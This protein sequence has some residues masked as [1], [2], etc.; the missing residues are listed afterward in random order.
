MQ[1][2]FEDFIAIKEFQDMFP[3]EL[4]TYP[5]D[6]EIKLSIDLAPETKPVTKALHKMAP[7]KMRKLAKQMQEMLE[8]EAFRP[9]VSHKSI[10][11]HAKHL[12][13][14]G[15][16][17][18]KEIVC[19]VYKVKVLMVESIRANGAL[20]QV[21]FAYRDQFKLLIIKGESLEMS[22]YLYN[23]TDPL[24][25]NTTTSEEPDTEGTGTLPRLPLKNLLASIYTNMKKSETEQGKKGGDFAGKRNR[26]R[27]LTG[28]WGE[29]KG[30]GTIGGKEERNPENREER[31]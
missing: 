18:K 11:D 9:S 6:R 1:T 31:L 24:G 28:K 8:E 19:K 2:K 13:T 4:S 3:D 10:E 27:R 5:P 22:V 30:R 17:E 16:S 15:E 29:K 14:T 21:C 23:S 20:V 12:M 7:V 26:Q 25:S